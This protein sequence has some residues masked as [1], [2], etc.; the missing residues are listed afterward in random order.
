MADFVLDFVIDLIAR[1]PGP[2]RER[3]AMRGRVHARDRR[4]WKGRV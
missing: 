1:G 2:V 3:L 4:A